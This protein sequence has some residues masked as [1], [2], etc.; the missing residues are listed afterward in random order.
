MKKTNFDEIETKH[1]QLIDVAIKLMETIADDYEH[2]V[3]HQIDVVSYTKE[4]L[5]IIDDDIDP[6][7]AIISAYWHDV[8]RTKIDKGH[9]LLSTIMLKEEMLELGYDDVIISK[10]IKAIINHRYDGI[11]KTKEG[12]LLQDADKLGFIGINRWQECVRHNHP[13]DSIMELL[14]KLKDELLNYKESKLI[15]DRDIIKLR[16]FL[17]ENNNKNNI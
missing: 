10:C 5:S 15:Y 14:P 3:Y 1:R 13:L 16:K 4:L 11:P 12:L 7:V 8:G 9:E 2:N 6:E 17:E